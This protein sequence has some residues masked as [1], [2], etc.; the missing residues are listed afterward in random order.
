MVGVYS[1]TLSPWLAWTSYGLV[2]LPDVRLPLCP[3]T[4]SLP[5]LPVPPPGVR[6][7]VALSRPPSEARGSPQSGPS[8]TS[9][10]HQSRLIFNE[11]MHTFN[12][13]AD[14]FDVRT[15]HNFSNCL[16][17]RILPPGGG[18]VGEGV[19]LALPPELGAGCRLR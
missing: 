19:R 17:K 5:P 10:I 3:L 7:V 1:P 16:Y 4:T 14:K 9:S 15:A 13:R 18:G 11:K 6:D 8:P 12:P 2:A